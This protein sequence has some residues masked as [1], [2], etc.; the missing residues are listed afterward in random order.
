MQIPRRQPQSTQFQNYRLSVVGAVP[1]ADSRSCIAK[2]PQIRLLGGPGFPNPE[3]RRS[4]GA[5]R[6]RLLARVFGGTP[7]SLKK[8]DCRAFSPHFSRSSKS[9]TPSTIMRGVWAWRVDWNM[10]ALCVGFW[11]KSRS[12]VNEARTSHR[13]ASL[14]GERYWLGPA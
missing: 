10:R 3:L 7:Q 8:A 4:D 9:G 13:E 11:T 12:S 2:A 1:T 14:H 5:E 6:L